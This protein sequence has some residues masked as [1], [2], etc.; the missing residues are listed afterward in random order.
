[1]TKKKNES[2]QKKVDLAN[3]RNTQ[4]QKLSNLRE[5]LQDAE[6][7]TESL[8]SSQ[9]GLQTAI[10]RL[11]AQITQ[12]KSRSL[13]LTTK[14][15]PQTSIND[16]QKSEL[17]ALLNMSLESEKSL[18]IERKKQEEM[19]LALRNQEV[20]RTNL[21]ASVNQAREDLEKFKLK[22]TEYELSLI[23]I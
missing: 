7:K 16:D 12:L 14:E 20:D 13:E 18:E 5:R 8:K 4:S 9:Q 10:S 6:L 11:E 17:E 3:L 15:N 2:D 23:H 19:Q 21:N 1:M 22:Q